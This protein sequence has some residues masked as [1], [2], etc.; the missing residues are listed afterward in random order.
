MD[1]DNLL[2]FPRPWSK[3]G[4]SMEEEAFYI[5]QA[6]WSK[7]HQYQSLLTTD[8]RTKYNTQHTRFSPCF[9]TASSARSPSRVT[10]S[11]ETCIRPLGD[12]YLQNSDCSKDMQPGYQRLGVSRADSRSGVARVHRSLHSLKQR[13]QVHNN[14]GS[15][16]E[17][18]H[19]S[20]W[21]LDRL[22]S[23]EHEESSADI[24]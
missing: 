13:L 9:R 7:K 18:L 4:N 16:S 15:E 2:H 8:Y 17:R 6:R 22:Q 11:H 10:R 3:A 19:T 21:Q 12:S 14:A 24:A 23:T 1:T 5:S 20:L